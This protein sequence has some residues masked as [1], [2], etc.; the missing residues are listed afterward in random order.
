MK[1]ILVEKK[2]RKP[3]VDKIRKLVETLAKKSKLELFHEESVYRRKERAAQ[4]KRIRDEL[5][6]RDK[7]RAFHNFHKS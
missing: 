5:S 3:N 6:F 4:R 1:R 7:L 2:P